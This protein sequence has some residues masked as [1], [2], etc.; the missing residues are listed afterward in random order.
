MLLLVIFTTTE[1]IELFG[2]PH[3]NSKEIYKSK[4]IQ[5]DFSDLVWSMT[6]AIKESV[7]NL[8]AHLRK[9]IKACV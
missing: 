5:A 8:R 3:S 2:L 9:T 4:L 1:V 7:A 6:P